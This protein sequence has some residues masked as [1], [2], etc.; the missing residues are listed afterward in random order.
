MVENRFDQLKF[1]RPGITAQLYIAAVLTLPSP[2]LLDARISYAKSC[3]FAVVFDDFFDAG[4]SLDELVNLIHCVEKWNINVDTDCCSEEVRILFLALKAEV[5]WTRDKAFKLQARDITSDVIE[6]WLHVT[7]AMLREHI[8]ARDSYVPTLDEFVENGYVA[9]ALGPIVLP[10]LL[11]MTPN[12][13]KEIIQSSEYQ[14]LYKITS[15]YCRLVND[16]RTVK[17]DIK[18]GRLNVLTLHENYGKSGI[19]EEEVAK[20]IEMLIDD[21][22]KRLMQ[23]VLEPSECIVL[24]ACKDAFWKMFNL[25]S[26][27]YAIDDGVTGS[28]DIRD[29]VKQMIYEPVSR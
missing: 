21:Q 5:F 10:P 16:I 12:L 7:K 22:K 14:K 3:I 26:L 28:N 15:T 19:E 11:L 2:E 6:S 13:S 24:R 29:I 25:V 17:R 23:L 20:E 4:G 1:V 27:Y 8:W 9:V 18:E